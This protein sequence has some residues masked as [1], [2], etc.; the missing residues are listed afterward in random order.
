MKKF[1]LLFFILLTICFFVGGTNANANE[2]DSL[3]LDVQAIILSKQGNNTKALSLINKAIKQEPNNYGYYNNRGIIKENLGD[4]NG[5][6]ADYTYAIKLNPTYEIAY[7]NRGNLYKKLNN[8]DLAAVDLSKYAALKPSYDSY[9]S[10]GYLM[11]EGNQNYKSAIEFFTKA[12]SYIQPEIDK[13]NKKVAEGSAFGKMEMSE[14]E[15]AYYGRGLSYYF[16][17][18]SSRAIQDFNKAISY[19]SLN[20]DAYYFRGIAKALLGDKTSAV[21]D[22]NIAKNQYSEY[23]DQTGYKRTIETIETVQRLR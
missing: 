14:F 17:K 13:F 19:K 5:A 8:G 11:L 12:I 10:L 20:P 3:P 2:L 7:N 18:D 16:M 9:T 23:G 4:Y 1:K 21:R 6:I 22:L 15:E